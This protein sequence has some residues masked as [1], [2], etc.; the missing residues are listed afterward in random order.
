MFVL[1]CVYL[2]VLEN[3]CMHMGFSVRERYVQLS[4]VLCTCRQVYG[5]R[6]K[7]EASL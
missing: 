4:I 6:I 3:V 2:S 7:E 5:R 1:T